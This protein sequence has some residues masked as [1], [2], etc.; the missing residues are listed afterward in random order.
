MGEEPDEEDVGRQEKEVATLE[1]VREHP[2]RES[3]GGASLGGEEGERPTSN[4]ESAVSPTSHT[5]AFGKLSV[6][7]DLD[8]EQRRH[9][10]HHDSPAIAE[11]TDATGTEKPRR[12]SLMD[13]EIKGAEEGE[14]STRRRERR[15][16]RVKLV[17]GGYHR[18]EKGNWTRK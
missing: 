6:N 1:Q 8:P 14:R 18:D 17:F 13:V 15:N 3:V 4:R 10:H 2:G 12:K 9:S 16:S 7:D 11:E 5:D